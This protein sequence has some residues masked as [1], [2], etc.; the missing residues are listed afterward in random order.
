MKTHGIKLLTFIFS[1]L[2]I[3]CF[4]YA[5]AQSMAD[6]PQG[7]EGIIPRNTEPCLSEVQRT[8]LKRIISENIEQLK[9][10]GRYQ[11]INRSGGH[12][13]FNWPV[14]QAAGFD[15]NSNWATINYVDHNPNFPDQISDYECGTRSYDTASGYN[16]KGFDISSW[17]FWWKQMD[18]DQAINIAAADGQIVAKQDGSFDRNC[19]FNNETP[20]YISLQHS[21]GSVTWYL[22][23]KNGGLTSK[24]IGDSVT[25]GEFLGVIG[26]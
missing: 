25:Q 1:V 20:N 5:V 24:G 9:A 13:L 22:H 7:G 23:M 18:L 19:G 8:A 15:Y 4:N 21:D 10:A 11:E 12:P 17:P 2:S 16:H 26:S 3:F 14:T 6:T